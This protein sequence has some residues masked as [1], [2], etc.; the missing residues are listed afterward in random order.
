MAE[1]GP[2]DRP[3][4]VAGVARLLR[5]GIEGPAEGAVRELRGTGTLP[6][7]FLFHPA[8]GRRRSTAAW[9]GGCRGSGPASVSNDCQDP[10]MSPNEP[11]STRELIRR[12]RPDGPWALGGWSYGGLLAQETARLLTAHGRVEALLLIDSVLPLPG[13]PVPPAGLARQRFA[14]FAAYVERTYGSPLPLPYDELAALDDDE[15]IA[16]VVKALEQAVDL[17]P[18]VLEHQR[19]S[20]LDLRSGERHTR[21]RTT[22]GPCCAGRRCPPRTPSGTRATSGPTRRWAGTP[23][24]AT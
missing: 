10:A 4:T 15:Q 20:Y 5:P 9:S 18:A 13:P 11:P 7:M 19:T 22:A 24:A 6:P 21:A 8:G 3:V 14:D 23:T 12:R 2:D 17:P 16:R 1:L